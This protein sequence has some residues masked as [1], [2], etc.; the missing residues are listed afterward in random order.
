MIAGKNLS[1]PFLSLPT[2]G[3]GAGVGGGGSLHVGS[4]V[5]TTAP[6]PSQE[7]HFAVV[8]AQA[9]SAKEPEC[10]FNYSRSPW[11][12]GGSASIPQPPAGERVLASRPPTPHLHPF[13]IPCQERSTC[14]LLLNVLRGPA[15]SLGPFPDQE[16]R[17]VGCQAR[18]GWGG[19]DSELCRQRRREVAE[20]GTLLLLGKNSP[21]ATH[22]KMS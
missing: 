17:S 16:A 7:V 8:S 1:G 2:R 13:P 20:P 4:A 9:E 5:L 10:G 11:S 18:G 14:S 15:A 3:A 21:S 6:L 22:P 19:G 12:A